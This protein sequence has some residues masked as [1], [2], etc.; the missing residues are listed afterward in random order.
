MDDEQRQ[1][2]L[3]SILVDLVGI[4]GGA[5]GPDVWL[6]DGLQTEYTCKLKV[7]AIWLKIVAEFMERCFVETEEIDP[8]ILVRAFVETAFREKI[9]KL[10]QHFCC[11]KEEM[12]DKVTKLSEEYEKL[13]KEK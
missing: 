11:S 1:R 9:T 7:P 12:L 13:M 4:L 2:R 10:A 8:N 5:V 6:G 3:Q